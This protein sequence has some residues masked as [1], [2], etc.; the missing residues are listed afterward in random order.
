M[1]PLLGFVDFT[2]T[3]DVDPDRLGA[4]VD[5]TRSHLPDLEVVDASVCPPIGS[6]GKEFP[7]LDLTP[8]NLAGGDGRYLG[9]GS[10]KLLADVGRAVRHRSNAQLLS[11][12]SLSYKERL[13]T[14]E[15]A[16]LSK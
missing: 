4:L 15:N 7:Y 8:T 6:P 2:P 13:G 10:S 5:A 12:F 16:E 1:H 11:R 14:K 3:R 9:I